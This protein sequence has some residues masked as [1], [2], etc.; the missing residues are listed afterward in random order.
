M[1]KQII[2]TVVAGLILFAIRELIL[3]RPA[4]PKNGTMV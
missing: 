2:S 3:N 4:N 1:Q